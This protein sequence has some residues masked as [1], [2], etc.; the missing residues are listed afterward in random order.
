M[1]GIDISRNF[2]RYARE[3]EQGQPLGIDYELASAVAVPF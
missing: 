1:T 3:D 2:V